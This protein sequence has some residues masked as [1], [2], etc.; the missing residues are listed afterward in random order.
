MLSFRTFRTVCLV[1]PTMM[2]VAAVVAYDG[3]RFSC[4]RASRPELIRELAA[5]V[6]TRAADQLWPEEAARVNAL[7]E[8]RQLERAIS[9][10]FERVGRRWDTEWLLVEATPTSNGT[11]PRPRTPA[12]T[13][14]HGGSD[15]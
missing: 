15:S 10:Y 8:A 7:L 14:K 5:Y 12:R 1:L 3:V 9:D 6:R 11:Q 2:H 4:A 13:V